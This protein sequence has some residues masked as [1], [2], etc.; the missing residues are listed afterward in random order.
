MFTFGNAAQPHL[1]TSRK[2]HMSFG[3]TKSLM[4]HIFEFGG[5]LHMST[6]K[7]TSALDL[8]LIWKN[9][10]LLVAQMDT[11][12][13]CSIILHTTKRTVI[14]EHAEFDERYFPSLK[15]TPLTPEPFEQ[16]P[17]IPFTPVLDLAN[18]TQILYRKIIEMLLCHLLSL[19]LL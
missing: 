18:Q 12:D 16:P 14:S 17:S 15:H 6:S 5:A 3:I 2:C 10:F 1:F 19:L 7:R 4:S 11:K 9:V 8:A 13:G